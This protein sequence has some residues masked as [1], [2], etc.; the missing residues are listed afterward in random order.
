VPFTVAAGDRPPLI[1]RDGDGRCAG[2]VRRLPAG[3]I[4][5]FPLAPAWPPLATDADLSSSP[6]R[7]IYTLSPPVSAA[8][9]PPLLLDRCAGLL[10]A[11]TP[12]PAALVGNS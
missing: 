4:P 9:S 5:F 3:Q 7:L 6:E 1:A 12:V 10:A 11:P 2:G 8:G